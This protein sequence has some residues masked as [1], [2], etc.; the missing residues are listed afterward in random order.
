MNSR[1]RLAKIGFWG[2]LD[3]GK[4]KCCCET[5]DGFHCGDGHFKR[6]TTREH[7]DLLYCIYA[8]GLIPLLDSASREGA[9][10][11]SF[12]TFFY[13]LPHPSQ[14]VFSGKIQAQGLGY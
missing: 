7:G 12:K 5:R 13:P 9:E 4:E 8:D 14:M 3:I 6:Q 1:G 2:S 10:Q 11:C